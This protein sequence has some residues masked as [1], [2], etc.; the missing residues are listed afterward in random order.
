MRAIERGYRLQYCPNL[1]ALNIGAGETTFA[2]P[3]TERVYVHSAR[4]YFG[5][6]RYLYTRRNIPYLIAFVFLF[7]LHL[8]AHLVRTH[9]MDKFPLIVKLA[10]LGT[11][12]RGRSPVR[13]NPIPIPRG[14]Y[15]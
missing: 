3:L 1:K 14:P 13:R 6:K 15:A 8:T 10:K 2:D 11:L 12:L 9:S 5:I 4:L 7:T